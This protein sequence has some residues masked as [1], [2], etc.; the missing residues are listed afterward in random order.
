[1]EFNNYFVI[2][3]K[4]TFYVTH[5]FP[6]WNASFVEYRIENVNTYMFPSGVFFAFRIEPTVC[7]DDI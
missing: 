6:L 2:I 7:R 3:P 5:F 1:M 4:Q